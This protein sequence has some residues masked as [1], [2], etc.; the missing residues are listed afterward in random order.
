M[1]GF[2]GAPVCGV[3]HVDKQHEDEIRARLPGEDEAVDAAAVFTYLSDST[4]VRLLS[5]LAESDMCVCEMA[6][7]LGMSQPA[8]SHHLRSLRQGDVIRFRKQGQRTMYYLSDN[9][10]GDT[11]RK[12]LNVVASGKEPV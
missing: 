2:A 5:M 10:T 3:T 4:R 8:V 1:K 9:E 6:D 11:V 7:L 12:L